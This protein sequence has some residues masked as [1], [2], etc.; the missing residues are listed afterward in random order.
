M[1]QAVLVVAALMAACHL[2]AA[3]MP[4]DSAAQITNTAIISGTSAQGGSITAK[5]GKVVPFGFMAQSATTI[6]ARAT[7]TD[8]QSVSPHGMKDK[9]Y[10]RIR[11]YEKPEE[12]LDVVGI[13]QSKTQVN[14]FDYYNC[15]V[16]LEN[17]GNVVRYTKD[18]AFI[19]NLKFPVFG[20]VFLDVALDPEIQY[21]RFPI[22]T[23]DQWVSKSTGTVELMKFFKITR[24]TSTKFT[25]LGE[26]DV[27]IDGKIEH[28]FRIGSEIDKG[29]GK[30]DHEEEWY[31][32]NI[33]LIY[34]TTDAYT[35]ELVK[36]VPG[37]GTDKTIEAA[38]APE[39][40]T[41]PAKL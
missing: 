27:T 25:V 7:I 41:P 13:I 2:S 11:H 30:L 17:K 24:Q 1:K 35:L 34:Q 19:S 21:M 9:W 3:G 31:A 32:V 14:G 15:F 36:Y 29:E 26:I 39:M 33:G 4:V 40:V 23:G 28:A 38:T 16:P 22:V 10:Y 6:C 18:G 37:N 20:F 8:W 12:V 5:A